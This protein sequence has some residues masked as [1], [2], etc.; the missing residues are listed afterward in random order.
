[1]SDNIIVLKSAYNKTQDQ[2][3]YIQPC[4]D[5]VTGMYPKCVREVEDAQTHKMILSEEDVIEASDG[6]QHKSSDDL[7]FIS[8][9]CGNSRRFTFF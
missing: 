1:M 7:L 5:P 8:L 3:Y 2:V 9:S 6:S 4:I